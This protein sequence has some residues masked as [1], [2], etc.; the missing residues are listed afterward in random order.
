MSDG[1]RRGDLVLVALPG[2]FGKPRPAVVVQSN[3]FNP[4]HPSITLVP[5][6]SDRQPMSLF[7]VD[8]A[9]GPDTGLRVPSQA[10]VDKI[11]SQRRDK[12]GPV[13][14]SLD[15]ASMAEI[16]AA[17]RLWLDLA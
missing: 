1:I 14:G 11:V 4:T 15:G 5:V 9:P 16:D 2:G 13:I 3:G 7:R 12:I 17:L 8:L 10:M 6:T